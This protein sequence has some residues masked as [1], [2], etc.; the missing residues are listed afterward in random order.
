MKI[1][2]IELKIYRITGKQFFFQ[3]P[4]EW[5]EECELTIGLT[6]SVL[7]ELEIVQPDPRVELIIKPWIEFSLEAL[8]KGGWHTPVLM[9]D[10]EI[11]SQGVVPDKARLKEKLEKALTR[12]IPNQN[13]DV[14]KMGFAPSPSE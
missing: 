4:H 2:P 10:G 3:V 11:F 5:C 6:K 13:L 7:R 9:I 12:F 14:E 1:K 8:S